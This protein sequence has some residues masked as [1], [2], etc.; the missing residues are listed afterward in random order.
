MLVYFFKKNLCLSKAQ[1]KSRYLEKRPNHVKKTIESEKNSKTTD[2]P[3]PQRRVPAPVKGIFISSSDSSR[4]S[5]PAMKRSSTI[6]SA[7]VKT[8]DSSSRTRAT[9]VNVSSSSHVEASSLKE[10]GISK[11]ASKVSRRSLSVH[12]KSYS[13][14]KTS[15]NFTKIEDPPSIEFQ[16][17]GRMHSD[18]QFH[19]EEESSQKPSSLGSQSQN[20]TLSNDSLA[21]VSSCDEINVTH[22]ERDPKARS[23]TFSKTSPSKSALRNHTDI[24]K[25]EILRTPLSLANRKASPLNAQRKMPISSS[26]TH[27]INSIGSP[28]IPSLL[29]KRSVSQ[30]TKSPVLSTTSS[31]LAIP[32][33]T[34]RS[35]SSVP[36][37]SHA[38]A[39]SFL[40]SSV[41]KKPTGRDQTRVTYT[42][43]SQR[44]ST[45]NTSVSSSS[46]AGKVSSTKSSKHSNSVGKTGNSKNLD[47]VNGDSSLN[48]IVHPTVGPRSGTFLKD[49]PT[50]LKTPIAENN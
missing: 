29:P 49:E 15:K 34:S 13:V 38:K 4:N 6:S 3:V 31:R 50:I 25:D 39:N 35:V 17:N 11:N 16:S 28:H 19:E 32:L 8:G 45:G 14:A 24:K 37:R 23:S 12:D 7:S 26:K 41:S 42:A 47:K 44:A 22:S 40:G 18:S 1:V 36:D 10:E 30:I 46:L 33:R 9:S 43:P 21:T 27:D 5:S 2:A 20:L 48:N